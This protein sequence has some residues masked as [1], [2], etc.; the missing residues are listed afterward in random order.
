MDLIM[1][2]TEHNHESHCPWCDY[3]FQA[4][5]HMTD[6]TAVPGPGDLTICINCASVLRYDDNG[7]PVKIPD[8]ELHRIME[9]APELAANIRKMQ[10]AVKELDRTDHDRNTDAPATA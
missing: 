6:D 8:A 1:K 9:Q 7:L 4:S 5:S 10:H 3:L 2:T